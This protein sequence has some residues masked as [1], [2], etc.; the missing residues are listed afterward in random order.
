MNWLVFA[1]SAAFFM[2]LYNVFIKL[3]AGNIHQV[4]G[5]VVLQVVAALAGLVALLVLKA[6]GT[7][8]PISKKGLAFA[9]LAGLC[10]G[11]AEILSFYTFSSGTLASRGVPVIVGG[12]VVIAAIIGLVLLR[13]QL[14]PMQIVGAG[15][16]V[17]GLLL[18]AR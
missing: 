7:P 11:L 10:V 9:A 16:V 14:A 8:M 3:S 17:V 2:A 13:E 4:V 15:L 1:I 5:A 6:Q 18:L 12:T